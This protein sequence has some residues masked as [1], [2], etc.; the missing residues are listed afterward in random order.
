M[1]CH[2]LRRPGRRERDT[3]VLVP[4]QMGPT[5]AGTD[6]LYPAGQGQRSVVPIRLT[7]SRR[8]DE[9]LANAAG[10]FTGT[11]NGYTWHHVDDFNPQSGMGSVE[12]IDEDTHKATSLIPVRLRSTRSTMVYGTSVDKET[13]DGCFRRHCF[14]A[15]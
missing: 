10:G 6:H 15:F 14:T 3:P 12:L 8:A 13:G 5:F 2:A 7:G 11:P 4:R 1:R 9:K